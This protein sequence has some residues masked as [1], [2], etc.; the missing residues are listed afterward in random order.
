MPS[1]L[2]IDSSGCWIPVEAEAKLDHAALQLR[3][4]RHRASNSQTLER[5]ECL[6]GRIVGA[7]VAE[8]VSELALVLG[9]DGLIQRHPRLGHI[10]GLVDMLLREACRLGQLVTRGLAAQTGL[11]LPPRPR[12]LHAALLDVGGH[13]DRPRLT[14]DRALARLSDPPGGV[15]REL[16]PTSP[17]ELLDC[18]VQPDD[19]VLDQVEQ[20][21]VVSLVA[22]RDR[23]HEPQV[24]VDH[25]LLGRGV[26]ALDPLGQR[27]LFGCGEQRKATG[28][29][30]EQG[31]CVRRVGSL[32][33]LGARGREDVDL[34]R[35]ELSAQRDELL[36]VEV[37]L[38]R[39]RLERALLERAALFCGGQEGLD[40]LFD[41]RG[42]VVPHFLP[43]SSRRCSKRS[44]RL[45]LAT[46]RSTPV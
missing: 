1:S 4:A 39:E 34:A 10:E 36:L 24:G 15:R 5:L 44:M 40:W 20:R 42:Q 19:A 17:V 25:P 18:A 26:T 23:D 27:D 9:A 32:M 12:Q 2:P 28:P 11:Q 46:A 35:L 41:D 45:P 30:H 43:A 37:V 7:R 3:Q 31:Q 13:A 8:E 14:G 22:L 38:G 33:R 6:L 29:V 21:D 16:E